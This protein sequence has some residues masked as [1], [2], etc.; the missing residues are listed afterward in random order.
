[1]GVGSKKVFW[2]WT[3]NVELG[4]LRE[5]WSPDLEEG[6]RHFQEQDF[7]LWEATA[8]RAKGIQESHTEDEDENKEGEDENKEA[9][10][11]DEGSDT[12]E[13]KWIRGS[14]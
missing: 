12:D 6:T 10:E 2:Y 3:I 14:G 9:G 1:M 11:A 7:P 8:L 5:F 4:Y 13:S